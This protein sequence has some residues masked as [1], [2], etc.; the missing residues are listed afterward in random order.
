MTEG[1]STHNFD[2]LKGYNEML[3]RT[4]VSQKVLIPQRN[5]STFQ[6]QC[7]LNRNIIPSNLYFSHTILEFKAF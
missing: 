1:K 7:Y 5:L 6:Q 4:G 3:T 2:A